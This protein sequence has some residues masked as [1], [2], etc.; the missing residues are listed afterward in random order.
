[1]IVFLLEE[2]SMKEFLELFLP[3][4]F[5]GM[6]FICLKHE[7]KADLEKSIPRKLKAWPDARFVVVRDNHGADC[8]KLKAR[9]KDLCEKAG[10]PDALVRIV[11]QELESWFFGTPQTLAKV[12]ND[13]KLAGL[14]RQAKYRN[15]DGVPSP[16]SELARLAPE[17][18]KRDGARRMGTAMPLKTTENLSRSFRVFIEGV[19]KIHGS[20]PEG[21][22]KPK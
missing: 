22:S 10:R 5:A 20:K 14:G 1:M 4:R 16:S 7:G 21:K 15:P 8:K 18:R 12:Y 11:C 17:F 3:R 9:L 13:H 2:P 6:E 19:E